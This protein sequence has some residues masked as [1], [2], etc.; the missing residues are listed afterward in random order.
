M[1]GNQNGENRGAFNKDNLK[2]FAADL[3][4]DTAK[5]NDCLDTGKFTSLVEDE[6]QLSQQLGISSTPTI[7]INGRP[8]LGAQPF[9]AFQQYIQVALSEQE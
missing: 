6:Y 4:L 5:F 7:L 8:V 3:E 1:Y 9:E 2:R